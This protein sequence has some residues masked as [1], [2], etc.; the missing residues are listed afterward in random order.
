MTV[1]VK[2]MSKEELEKLVEQAKKV[3]PYSRATQGN[4][5]TTIKVEVLQ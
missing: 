2:G 1:K 5:T 4:V 3:C